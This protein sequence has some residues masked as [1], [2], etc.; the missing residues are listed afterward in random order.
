MTVVSTVDYHP[1]KL[2]EP[3]ARV[4]GEA[5]LHGPH[6]FVAHVAALSQMIPRDLNHV[7]GLFGAA[8][9]ALSHLTSRNYQVYSGPT[10]INKPLLS[11]RKFQ[12][13]RVP[14]GPGTKVRPLGVRSDFFTQAVSI[15]Q[16]F[17][18]N[19]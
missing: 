9:S 12:G 18:Q 15:F 11:L 10:R 1:G 2:P 5:S 3:G 17:I 19:R 6:R 14:A 13:F 8:G 4:C 16:I 7:A